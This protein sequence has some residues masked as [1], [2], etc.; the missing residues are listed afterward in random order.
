MRSKVEAFVCRTV[1]MSPLVHTSRDKRFLIIPVPS[2]DENFSIENQTAV[3]P[4]TDNQTGLLARQIRDK[5]S[6]HSNILKYLD[7]KGIILKHSDCKAKTSSNGE[8]S[9]QRSRGACQ[10]LYEAMRFDSL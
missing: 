8:N 1:M 6:Q 7:C 3:M 4:A 2:S 5:V 9:L 10:D